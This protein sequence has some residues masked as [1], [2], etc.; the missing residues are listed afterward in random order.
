[1]RR[2]AGDEKAFLADRSKQPKAFIELVWMID[3]PSSPSTWS[4]Y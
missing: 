2:V 4:K 3:N 1:M